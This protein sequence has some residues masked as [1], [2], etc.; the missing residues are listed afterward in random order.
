[1]TGR[2]VRIGLGVTFVTTI[3]LVLIVLVPSRRSLFVG[4]YEL[5]LAGIAVGAL[6]SSFRIFEPQRGMRSPFERDPEKPEDPPLVAELDRI[7]RLVVLGGANEFDLHYR[8][9][10]LLR[11]IAAER[12]YDLYGVDL[13][14]EPERAQAL[15][16]EELWA[17]VRPDRQVGRRSWPG[18]PAAD[19][20]GYV[21][22]L[23][24][25]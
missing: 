18:L 22:R 12:L 9:R 4:I 3:L 16:G 13:D 8:L 15:L 6:V 10:P 11:Q 5:V 1:V 17:I 24:Q 19:L 14:G 7:D 23:E 21:A 20:A 25:L 2:L